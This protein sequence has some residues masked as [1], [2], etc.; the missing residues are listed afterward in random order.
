MLVTTSGPFVKLPLGSID[1]GCVAAS[2]SRVMA[3][4]GSGKEVYGSS[5]F[6][7]PRSPTKIC[8]H[9]R[10]S[11]PAAYERS[12]L[13]ALSPRALKRARAL[14]PAKTGKD[15]KTYDSGRAHE[16]N[17]PFA[18]QLLALSIDILQR[19]SKLLESKWEHVG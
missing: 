11:V 12:K 9:S 16:A 17:V 7:L 15:A 4:V 1:N 18:S 10:W 6:T 3:Q 8:Q 19:K 5:A 14:S 2:G 13:A